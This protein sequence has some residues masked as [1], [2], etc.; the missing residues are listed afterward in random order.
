M[1]NFKCFLPAAVGD[2]TSKAKPIFTGV[3]TANTGVL[4][5]DVLRQVVL[6]PSLQVGAPG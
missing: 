5:R 2:M 3:L 6:H 1:I 4:R